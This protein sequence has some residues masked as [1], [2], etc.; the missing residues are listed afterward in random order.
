V[1]RIIFASLFSVLIINSFS[2]INES[3]AI[4][5]GYPVVVGN[6][7]L[8]NKNSE[9]KNENSEFKYK[10]VA[11]IGIDYSF[12][13]MKD[14]EFGLLFNATFLSLDISNV[15]LMMLTPKL[16][17]D[18][19]LNINKV[20]IKPQISFGYS[21]WRF[22]QPDY[23]IGEGNEEMTIKGIN[24]N[25]NGLSVM[26]ANKISLNMNKRI[27]WY[28]EFAYEFTRLEKPNNNIIDNSHNRNL[29]L[30]YP[31]VG[32]IWNFRN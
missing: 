15:N 30:L 25:Y 5:I 10:G 2:Q 26:F 29:Q 11:D 22:T 23:Q 1:K 6:N 3:I 4:K 12:Y 28:L 14:L 20:E 18:Y 32:M 13:R 16:K 19:N 21:N 7:F 9:Y 24:V 8:N 31:G 17:M 27:N